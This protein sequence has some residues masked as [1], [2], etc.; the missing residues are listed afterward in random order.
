MIIRKQDFALDVDVAATSQYSQTHSLC[1]CSE[2]RNLY[3]QIADKLP[4]KKKK[5][6][7]R[8]EKRAVLLIFCKGRVLVKKREEALLGG[9]YVFP[10]ALNENNPQKL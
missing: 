6:P 7:Q 4:N 8:V 3:A 9:L 1:D 5:K 10:D 2:C